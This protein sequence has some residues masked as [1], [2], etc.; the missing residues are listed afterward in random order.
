MQSD[1]G[2]AEH[3]ESGYTTTATCILMERR[4]RSLRPAQ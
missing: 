1:A 2:Y 4:L 3:V